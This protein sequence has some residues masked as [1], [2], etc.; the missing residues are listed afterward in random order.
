MD[1]LVRGNSLTISEALRAYSEGRVRSGL[2]HL[3]AR[4]S[5]VDVRVAD[6]N[7]PRG[8][9]DIRAGIVAVLSHGGAV[10]VEARAADAYAAVEHAVSRL[11]SRMQHRVRRLRAV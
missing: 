8:G 10:F 11:V 7:G 5:S 3:T 1:V 9:I 4:I 6:T 2:E